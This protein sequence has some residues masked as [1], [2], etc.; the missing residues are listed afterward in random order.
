MYRQQSV[1]LDL[2]TDVTH[3]CYLHQTRDDHLIG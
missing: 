1:T 2:D 3:Q